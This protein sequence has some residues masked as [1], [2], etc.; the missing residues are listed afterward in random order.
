MNEHIQQLVKEVKEGL[1]ALYGD[2]LKGVYWY[3]SYARGEEEAESDVDL[4]IVLDHIWHY[5]GEVDRTGQLISTLSLRYG[6]SLSPVFVTD[7]AWQHC[8]S[9]FLDNVREEAI[10]A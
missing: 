7:D 8:H 5:A 4:L 2:R 10:A 9:N 1:Q 6:V 3:G